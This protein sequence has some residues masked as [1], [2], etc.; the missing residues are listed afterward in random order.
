MNLLSAL[1]PREVGQGRTRAV[2]VHAG[3]HVGHA[4][5]GRVGCG[6]TL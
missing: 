6:R 1:G 3:V 4:R 2:P 5:G